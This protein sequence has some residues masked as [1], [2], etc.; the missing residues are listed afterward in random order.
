VLQV[1]A[2]EQSD[3]WY[4]ANASL[5]QKLIR[6]GLLS[7]EHSLHDALQPIFD[8][9][10]RLHPLPKEEEQHGEMLEFHQFV[11][12]AVGEGLRNSTSLPG[13][14]GMLKSVVKVT[15][16]RID[17]FSPP[18]MKLLSKFT[19]EH[20]HSSPSAQGY[21][22]NVR[23]VTTILD[24]C[25]MSVAFLGEQRRWLL[26]TL[27]VFVDKSKSASLCRYIL[28]LARTWA[29]HHQE[30]YPTMKEKATLSRR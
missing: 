13:V 2:S 28:D 15:P 7:D 24:I 1:I 10:I 25:Q 22:N 8:H 3:A 12:S 16:E 5:L 29:L 4:L 6:K 19:K 30:P 9:L 17:P 27:C 14:L 26:S 18:F 20:I 11:Y 21:E 23:L